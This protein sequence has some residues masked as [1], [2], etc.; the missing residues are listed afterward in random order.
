[1][2]APGSWH[3]GSFGAPSRVV[4]IKGRTTLESLVRVNCSTSFERRSQNSGYDRFADWIGAILLEDLSP[5]CRVEGSNIHPIDTKDADYSVDLESM[6][7][8][9]IP[10]LVLTPEGSEYEQDKSILAWIDRCSFVDKLSVL[11]AVSPAIGW[12]SRMKSG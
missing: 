2:E 10:V 1:M 9:G 3:D 12:R 5:W 6:G 11:C 4:V 7:L 8:G